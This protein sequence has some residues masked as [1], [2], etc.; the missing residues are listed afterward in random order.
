MLLRTV[1]NVINWGVAIGINTNNPV[2]ITRTGLSVIKI[3]KKANG[4]S[5]EH[6]QGVRFVMVLLYLNPGLK[7]ILLGI[8]LHEP[9]ERDGLG[10]VP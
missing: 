7:I 8:E 9:A 4:L 6:L 1:R 3:L 10:E 2:R 5:Y